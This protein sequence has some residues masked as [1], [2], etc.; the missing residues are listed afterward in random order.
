MSVCDDTHC[1]HSQPSR[2]YWA[3]TAMP[4][5]RS[6]C[7]ATIV[8]RGASRYEVPQTRAALDGQCRGLFAHL[9]RSVSLFLQ[10]YLNMERTLRE[11]S[12]YDRHDILV[13]SDLRAL[14]HV[15]R[16][17]EPMIKA[18]DEA[19]AVCAGPTTGFAS[20]YALRRYIG[21]H[22]SYRF[23]AY[24]GCAKQSRRGVT[25]SLSD[26]ALTGIAFI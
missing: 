6:D 7:H 19:I 13:Q 10:R 17:L 18:A 5:S 8:Q 3:G 9:C 1:Y 24:V 14:R 21:G 23:T 22:R 26:L 20:A 15:T 4:S 12:R 25:Y 11:Q 2:I 16:S